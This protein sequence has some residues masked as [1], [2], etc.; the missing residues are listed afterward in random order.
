MDTKT[1]TNLIAYLSVLVAIIFALVITF[2][3]VSETTIYW[4][5][6]LWFFISSLIPIINT[7][8]QK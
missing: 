8:G 2:L 1:I 6:A 7:K 5:I 4:I 3:D